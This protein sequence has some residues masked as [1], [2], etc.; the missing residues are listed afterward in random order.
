MTVLSL[1]SKNRV[2]L[3]QAGF[4]TTKRNNYPQTSVSLKRKQDF[5]QIDGC[6]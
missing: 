1:V 5:P 6:C 4:F 3:T 2:S